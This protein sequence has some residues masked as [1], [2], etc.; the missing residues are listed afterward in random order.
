MFLKNTESE[1]RIVDARGLGCS[2]VVVGG[3]GHCGDGAILYLGCITVNILVVIFY[4]G[5]ARHYH[6]GEAMV[7][8]Q[9]ISLY[10]FLQLHVTL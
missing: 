5:F 2:W 8:V 3:G 7:S 9:R 1:S 4:Y 6:W 10:Y